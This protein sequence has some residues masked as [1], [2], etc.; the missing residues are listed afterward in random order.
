MNYQETEE[1]IIFK[2]YVLPRSSK[3][4]ISGLYGD[5]LKLKLTA[6]PV[7]G[8]ANKK[9]TKFLSKI[10]KIPASSVEIKSGQ[11]NRSKQILL[12]VDKSE[13]KALKEILSDIENTA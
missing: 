4:M 6:P 9:C 12:R 3:N 1:G 5:A 11:T 13:R 2:V 7:D 8:E 10:F